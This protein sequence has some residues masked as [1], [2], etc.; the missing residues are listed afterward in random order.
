MGLLQK[1]YRAQM[2][3]K[4][5][6][7]SDSHDNKSN[8]EKAVEVF[9]AKQVKYVLHAGDMTSSVTAHALSNVDHAKF[10][11]VLGNCD[12]DISLERFTGNGNAEV[13]P[14]IYSGCIEGR[15]IYMTHSPISLERVVESGKYDIVIYGHTHKQDIRLVG[16]TLVINPGET[17]SCVKGSAHVVI[18]ELDDMSVETITL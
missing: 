13:H 18:I 2:N 3:M 11:G 8:V 10:I 9:A 12:K 4:I 7:I 17:R 16:S 1:L 6:I 14:G 15:R 5:G